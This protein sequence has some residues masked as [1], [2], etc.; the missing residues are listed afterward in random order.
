MMFGVDKGDQ[1]HVHMGGF[2]QK[3]HFKKWYK[4]I[5]LGVLDIMLMN[6]HI[7]WNLA[8]A[9]NGSNDGPR[10]GKF[11]AWRVTGLGPFAPSPDVE[12]QVGST[13]LSRHIWYSACRPFRPARWL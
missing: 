5:H 9:E 6:S 11:E 1:I 4:R 12:S 2:A 7:G 8:A 3:A 13:V 10:R